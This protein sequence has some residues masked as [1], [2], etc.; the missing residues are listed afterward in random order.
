MM[1]SSVS[2][3]KRLFAEIID[4]K[5]LNTE[6]LIVELDEMGYFTAP[7][8]TKY[9]GNYE[10]GLFDHSYMMARCLELMTDQMGLVWQDERSPWV[11]GLFH[12]LCKCDAY[13]KNM[14][15]TYSYNTE[16]LIPGHAE[17]S[18]IIAQQMAFLPMLDGEQV[19]CIRYHMGA[20]EGEKI[21]R[22]YDYAIRK[23]PNVLWTHT[24]DMYAS[25]VLGT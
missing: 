8:S 18:I 15:G 23:Y 7:A 16:Q 22:N 12:D 10:G 6:S 21:W 24:A 9:H 11:V 19:A 14:D 2:D 5:V 13:I 20:Y 3:R 1:H 25:K 17:K 4:D